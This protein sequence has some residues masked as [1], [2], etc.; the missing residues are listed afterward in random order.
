M[1]LALLGAG[2]GLAVAFACQRLI[3]TIDPSTLPRVSDLHLSAPVLAFT[4]VLA[5]VTAAIFGL[6]PAMQMARVGPGGALADGSRGSVDA[7]RSR[8]RSVLV[9]A[10]VAIAVVL[11]VAAGLLIRT[12]VSLTRVPSGL[13]ADHVLTLRLSP[14]PATYVSQAD[15]ARFF[16]AF[17][18]RVRALPGVRMAGATSGLPLADPSGDW[19]FDIQGRPFSPGRRHSGAADW[20]AVTPGYFDT[21]RVPLISGR[22]P[23]AGDDAGAGDNRVMFLNETAARQFFPGGDPIGHRLKLAGLNQPWRTVAGIVGDMHHRGLATAVPAEMFIPLAQFKHFSATG[24][25]RGLTVVIRTD[26]DPI[27]LVTPVRTALRGLDPEIPPARIRDMESVVATSVA[28]RRLNM[29]LMASFGALALTLA[30]IGVYGVMAY[31]VVK[32]TREMGVRLALGASADAVRALVIADGMRLVGLGLACGLG[33]SLAAGGL[34][35]HLLF[36]TDA[37]DVTTLTVA[38]CVLAAAG[39][40]ACVIPAR[41]A[42]RV[43]PMMALRAE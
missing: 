18:E 37:R 11:V 33:L 40:V 12:F 10:Q 23:F 30:A 25:A 7:M 14:P 35:Q 39:F 6:A 3:V 31:Q 2:L 16:D 24:Q 5:V 19:S 20:Y 8:T 28:D 17:L 4:L 32:R 34:I 9:V 1:L 29:V 15:I 26:M 36:A 42:T 13:Q 22:L 38:A 21:L 27:A 41:R 43:D